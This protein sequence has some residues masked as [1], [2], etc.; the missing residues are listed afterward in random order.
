MTRTLETDVG[1]VDVAQRVRSR[2]DVLRGAAL[3]TQLENLDFTASS[4]PG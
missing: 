4:P 2:D 3:V 1:M